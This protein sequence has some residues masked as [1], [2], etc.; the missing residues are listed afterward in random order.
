MQVDLNCDMGESFGAWRLGADG[1][2]L[3]HVTSINIACGFHAGDPSVMHATVAAAVVHGVAIGA[4]PGLPDLAGFGRREMS[5]TASEVYDLVAY[6]VG[7]LQ[8]I[9]TAAGATVQHVK[10]HGAL[11]TMAAIHAPL[12]DAI[13]RAIADVN[14][15]LALYG[16]SGSALISA[17]LDAGL[18]TVSEAFAD[19][20]YHAD[21]TLVPRSDAA[22]MITSTIDATAQALGMVT[23]GTVHAID[24]AIVHLVAETICI[25]GDAPGAAVIAQHLRTAF[26]GAGVSVRAPSATTHA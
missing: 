26:H 12:A 2:V 25:H 18:R 4:H 7:A 14:P 24:G 9:A 11:Y 21:G 15:A 19:R 6:Q 5:V 13:A 3:P 22:A 1:A 10:P 17:G 23:S 20:R 8:G 16:L